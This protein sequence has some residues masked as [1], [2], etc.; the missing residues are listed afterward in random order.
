MF[1]HYVS[2]PVA[3][4]VDLCWNETADI[5]G[6]GR[7]GQRFVNLTACKTECLKHPT[8]V[9]IDWQLTNATTTDVDNNCW[10]RESTA[11]RQ[12]PDDKRGNIT[13]YELDR[14]CAS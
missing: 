8:C 3:A 4:L 2:L 6:Y 14:Q 9:A 13:H 12:V 11:T 1:C 10:I 7:V 5:Q